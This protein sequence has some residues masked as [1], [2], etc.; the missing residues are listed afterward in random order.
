MEESAALQ[1]ARHALAQQIQSRA[2]AAARLREL[3]FYSNGSGSANAGSDKGSVA[4]V[5]AAA[6]AAAEALE[7][8]TRTSNSSSNNSNAADSA[9]KRANKGWTS[10]S[11]PYILLCESRQ[12]LT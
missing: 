12:W 1:R 5:V 10:I 4:G 3:T 11:Y 8:N 9:G 6:M 2:Q 7:Q